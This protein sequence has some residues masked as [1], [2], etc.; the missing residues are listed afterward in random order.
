MALPDIK[1][2]GILAGFAR[3]G[4]PYHGLC[5]GGVIGSSGK[6]ITQPLGGNAWLIDKALP[7]LDIAPAVVA[8]ELAAGREWRNY[9]LIAGGQVNGTWLPRRSLGGIYE[10]SAYIHI[11][12]DGVPWMITLQGANFPGG[13]VTRMLFDI[14][15]FGHFE[16]GVGAQTPV[17]KTVDVSCEA[18]ELSNP[19]GGPFAS[20]NIA[21]HD[22][23]TNGSKALACVWM[24]TDAVED[25]R[26]VFSCIE[27]TISGSGGA[28]GSGLT[29][30]ATEV[31]GQSEL[32]VSVTDG[33]S[34][35]AIDSGV[36]GGSVYFDAVIDYDCGSPPTPGCVYQ[37]QYLQID[38]AVEISWDQ[39]EG[40][41]GGY[42]A[43]V[44]NDAVRISC[45][46]CLYDAAGAVVAYRLK[47]VSSR[48][49]IPYSATSPTLYRN[50]NQAIVDDPAGGI[51]CKAY[52][53]WYMTIQYVEHEGWYLLQN[54]TEI[55]KLVRKQ[56]RL[57]EQRF[58]AGCGPEYTGPTYC[59]T[60][61]SCSSARQTYTTQGADVFT[62]EGSLAGSISS[63]LDWKYSGSVPLNNLSSGWR[64]G[65]ADGTAYVF[66]DDDTT[67]VGIHRTMNIAAF[68]VGDPSRTYGTIATPLG[69]K[70]SSETGGLYFS[71]QRKT[72]DF[73]FS[74]NPICYV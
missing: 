65:A 54:D 56:T 15:R 67:K 1:D 27:I 4:W 19:V 52:A 16:V 59:G 45:R 61:L 69:N 72:G 73:A 32:T 17:S 43:I 62:W 66:L 8:S 29:V 71:W 12:A 18:V 58:V 11:D 9:A 36:M 25:W 60:S 22:V 47:Q 35:P 46:F 64:Y 23:W 34:Y 10:G 38:S 33:G 49:H 13:N 7:A 26:E 48:T 31:K 42:A 68:F 5:E 50:P 24:Q 63:A 14:V 2:A 53:E 21:L 39:T 57:I 74:A 37:E 6:T 55:D 28:D 3:W 30:A 44:D 20:R 41:G 51:V 70:T 40:F